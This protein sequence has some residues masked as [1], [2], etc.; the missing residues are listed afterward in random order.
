[1]GAWAPPPAGAR[2]RGHKSEAGLARGRCR[3]GEARAAVAWPRGHRRAPR[4]WAWRCGCCSASGWARR[5]PRLRPR[6]APGVR[7]QV[8]E[9]RGQPRCIPACSVW[10]TPPALANDSA[11]GPSGEPSCRGALSAFDYPASAP[12]LLCLAPLPPPRRL[13]AGVV[14]GGGLRQA[15]VVGPLTARGGSPGTSRGSRAVQTLVPVPR[16]GSTPQSLHLPP[17]LENERSPPHGT[18]GLSGSR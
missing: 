4:P 12:A 10:D 16:R 5:P 1:M 7:P 18:P 11:A 8:S 6:P 2:V 14:W 9:P 15:L 17:A 3:A 13:S